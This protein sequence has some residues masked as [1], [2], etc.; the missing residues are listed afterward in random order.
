[1]NFHLKLLCSLFI[2]IYCQNVYAGPFGLK[3]G[4]K[5]D[6]I[7]SKA[8]MVAPGMYYVSVPKP[9]SSFEKY[10]VNIAPKTGLCYIK[11]IGK[12]IPTSVYG[13][14]LKS[15][16]NDMKVKLDKAYGKG[17]TTDKLMPNSIWHEANEWMK[18]LIKKERHLFAIWENSSGKNVKGDIVN[19]AMAAKPSGRS[20][21]Y[22]AIDYTFK[23]EDK[24]KKEISSQEDGAL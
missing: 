1:M 20:K 11:A 9:H 22:I 18:G 12:D 21:G 5:L 14:E 15:K 3:M 10:V 6:K 24:C 7:D 4:M 23:N 16:F 13:I 17:K 2:I 19:I 8:K